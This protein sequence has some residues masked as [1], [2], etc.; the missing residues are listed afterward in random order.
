MADCLQQG[1]DPALSETPW[2]EDITLA[3]AAYISLLREGL[4]PEEG[5]KRAFLF[6]LS[7]SL[8]GTVKPPAADKKVVV[9]TSRFRYIPDHI[10][11]K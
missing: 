8:G 2:E 10:S 3:A 1:V 7:P 4:L 11:N 6:S 5:L 9:I